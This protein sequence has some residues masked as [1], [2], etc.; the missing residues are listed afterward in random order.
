MT[1]LPRRG[2]RLRRPLLGR[3]PALRFRELRFRELRASP[4]VFVRLRFAPCRSPARR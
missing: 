1:A 3:P 2:I 4:P